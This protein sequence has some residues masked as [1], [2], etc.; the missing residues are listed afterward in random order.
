M[1]KVLHGSKHLLQRPAWLAAS[2][3][4]HAGMAMESLKGRGGS[5]GAL[6][7]PL[8]QKFL[9]HRNRRRCGDLG[10]V[11]QPLAGPFDLVGRHGAARVFCLSCRAL[12]ARA[13]V[14][15]RD[16][17]A[18]PNG[19]YPTGI[20]GQAALRHGLGRRVAAHPCCMVEDTG[21][22]VASPC[23]QWP[24]QRQCCQSWRKRTPGRKKP[25]NGGQFWGRQLSTFIQI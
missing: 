14:I 9:R 24:Q 1:C 25:H 15:A 8:E 10:M 7:K 21:G 3:R 5:N 6:K 11:I 16:A 22:V 12:G 20:A 17:G 19:L 13:E 4:P 2:A 23:R 18:L